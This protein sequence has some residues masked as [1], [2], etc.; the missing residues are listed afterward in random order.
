[1]SKI[2][3]I[4]L[5]ILGGT[6][7]IVVFGVLLVA[8]YPDLLILVRVFVTIFQAF[9]IMGGVLTLLGAFISI[10]AK[11]EVNK[12][13][14]YIIIEIGAITGGINIISILGATQ[15]RKEFSALSDKVVERVK[16]PICDYMNDINS[17][18][19]R[20]CGKKLENTT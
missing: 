15:L 3:G 18:L 17:R 8:L 2:G 14:G 16:C 12:K 20:Y 19:C 6:L 11:D 13:L 5:S 10:L 7:S 1:M 9:M 4:I